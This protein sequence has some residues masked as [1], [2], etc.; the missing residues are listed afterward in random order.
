MG[1]N[2]GTILGVISHDFFVGF[3]VSHF[4]FQLLNVGLTV[5]VSLG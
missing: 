1:D 5:G 3:D 4:G 2:V